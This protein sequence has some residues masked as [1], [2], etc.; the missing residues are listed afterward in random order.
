MSVRWNASLLWIVMRAAGIECSR[1]EV[2]N[3][4]YNPASSRKFPLEGQEEAS[5]VLLD[6]AKDLYKAET[7]RTT[8]V[9][10][11]GKTLLTLSGLL[12]PLLVAA[13]NIAG[14]VL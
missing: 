9:Q 4:R 12:F 14:P 5:S 7:E 3:R 6:L 10:E 2:E 11:K 1:E 8:S 13:M